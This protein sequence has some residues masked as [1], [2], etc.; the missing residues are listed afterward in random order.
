MLVST[1][2]S[3]QC[4]LVNFMGDR[5]KTLTRLAALATLSRSAGERLSRI[6]L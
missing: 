1:S 4:E 6:Q 5:K 2:Y 3:M